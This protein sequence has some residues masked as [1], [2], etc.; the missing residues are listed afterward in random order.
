MIPNTVA[1][2]TV[3]RVAAFLVAL[4]AVF[5]IAFAVGHAVAPDAGVPVPEHHST[6]TDLHGGHR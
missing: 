6:T 3:V 5:A 2:S 4:A 1:S